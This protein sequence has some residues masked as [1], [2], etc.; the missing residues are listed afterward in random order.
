MKFFSLVSLICLVVLS[1]FLKACQPADLEKRLR[2][3]HPRL[4]FTLESQERIEKFAGE[5]A[6]L[7]QSIET[8]VKLANQMILQ[9][10]IQYN[11]EGSDLLSKSRDC[12]SKVM[13]LSMAYRLTGELR[14]AR[15]AL[16]EMHAAAGFP[17][18]NPEHFLDVAEM[19]TALAIGY[20]WLFE[21][22]SD[23]DKRIIRTAL[24]EKGLKSGLE[25]YP[26]GFA[27]KINN[28]N[29]VCNGGM[30]MAA[31]AI[32]DEEPDLAQEVLDRALESLPLGLESFAPEGA[33]FEGPSYWMYGANYL[34]MLV[35]SLESALGTDYGLSASA[36]LKNSG[37]FFLSS[38]GPSGN[39]FNYADCRLN[40]MGPTPALFWLAEAFDEPFFARAERH[41][42]NGFVDELDANKYGLGEEYYYYRFY[43]LEIAWYD[44]RSPGDEDMVKL[45]SYFRGLNDVVYLRSSWEEDAF[46]VGFKA[47]KNGINHGHLD[48][49]SFVLE[50]NGQRWA[51][52]LGYDEYSLPGYF[53]YEPEAE[54]WKYF[55]IS[56]VSHNVLTING[57]NQLVNGQAK[58]IAYNS[59][60][61]LASAVID[62]TD[63]YEGQA[64]SVQRGM[65]MLGRKQCLVQDE[66]V[67]MKNNDTLRWAML[68]SAHIKLGGSRALLSKGGKYLTAEILWPVDAHFAIRS[69]KPTYHPDEGSNPGTSLLT[70]SLP[71]GVSDTTRLVIMLTPGQKTTSHSIAGDYNII[72]LNR[73]A[74]DF[75]ED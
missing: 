10:S 11:F 8:L 35:S 3:G 22:L 40:P 32:A 1:F 72:P 71:L 21:I 29:F 36:G 42:I 9:P 27:K 31:L 70:V 61:E 68:T 60:H 7:Q 26:D 37:H 19:S 20:D 44:P 73:W 69:T 45:D 51:E 59:E 64:V 50:A 52:E 17:S 43:P 18:W 16:D 62:L 34:A 13:T 65:A 47:G 55:R 6:L 63:V 57:Q 33:W 74:G 14:F 24:I 41:V 5:D 15:R 75:I 38:I 48:C 54:R 39:F 4:I 12:L 25:I 23:E 49:G 67:G 2:E 66:V 28:W 30:I 56:T 58:L 46:F 53:D